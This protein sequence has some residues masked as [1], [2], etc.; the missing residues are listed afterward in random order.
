MFKII[1]FQCIVTALVVFSN[2]QAFDTQAFD[3]T[4]TPSSKQ[5]S[6]HDFISRKCYEID[7]RKDQKRCIEVKKYLLKVRKQELEE[8][9]IVVEACT[10]SVLGGITG[11]FVGWYAA[12]QLPEYKVLTTLGG[13]LIGLLAG[14]VQAALVQ[15]ELEV[16]IPR[17][18]AYYKKCYHDEGFIGRTPKEVLDLL[19]YVPNFSPHEMRM[20]EEEIIKMWLATADNMIQQT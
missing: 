16:S 3:E 6:I 7:N 4:E 14:P 12:L 11:G 20:L 8:R 13:A 10:Y 2:A 9:N 1:H 19:E 15:Y 18:L 17:S 5:W